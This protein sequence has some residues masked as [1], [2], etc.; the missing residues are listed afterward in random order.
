MRTLAALALLWV[1]AC[2]PWAAEAKG[3]VDKIALLG[4]GWVAPLEIT[5]ERAR[6]GFDPWGRQ[7]IDWEGGVAAEPPAGAERYTVSFYLEGR[8]IYMVEYAP[9]PGGD[10]G[11]VY[12]PG[13]EDAAYRTNAGTIMWAS[14]DRWDPNGKWQHATDGWVALMPVAGGVRPPATGDGGL[15][16]I[17][18]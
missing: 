5:D 11:Y 8:V 17:S 10:G 13:P 14:T 12:I 6:A 9:D 3:P 18:R 16:H 4:D 2:L 1:A 15:R 7:F